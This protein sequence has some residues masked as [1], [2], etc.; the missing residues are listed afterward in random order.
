[1]SD[2]HFIGLV[3]AI[4]SS[5]EAAL[6]EGASPML[7]HLAKDGVLAR[8]TAARSL[9]L[10]EMLVAKS[11]GNLTNT[12]RATLYAA[13]DRVRALLAASEAASARVDGDTELPRF[14]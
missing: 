3:H 8:R 5:A 12:E 1:V 10:L 4:L 13:R 7:S 11:A 9:D 2:P 6:G 14:S